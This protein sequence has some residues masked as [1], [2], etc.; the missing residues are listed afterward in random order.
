MLDLVALLVLPELER[1]EGLQNPHFLQAKICLGNKSTT[2]IVVLL[3]SLDLDSTFLRVL[4]LRKTLP[5]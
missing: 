4:I 1:F 2:A 5:S 3:D